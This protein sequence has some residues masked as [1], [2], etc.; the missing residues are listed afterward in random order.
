MD[1]LT[2][3][4]TRPT[5]MVLDKVFDNYT[6]GFFQYI[7]NYTYGKDGINRRGEDA[8][9]HIEEA[10]S[11]FAD[12]VSAYILNSKDLTHSHDFCMDIDKWDRVVVFLRN[13]NIHSVAL[14]TSVAD[15]CPVSPSVANE[16]LH[17]LE[18]VSHKIITIRENRSGQ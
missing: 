16:Y 15:G 13:L 5:C 3:T 6:Y 11:E 4:F 2:I 18:V 12:E 9:K 14:L 1:K 17:I 8:S 7:L 10:V